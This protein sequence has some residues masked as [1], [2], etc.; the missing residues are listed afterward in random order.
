M[1]RR[2]ILDFRPTV[3]F[4]L[5]HNLNIGNL[6]FGAVG[7]WVLGYVGRQTHFRSVYHV[8]S[9]SLSSIFHTGWYPLPLVRLLLALLQPY[10]HTWCVSIISEASKLM[11]TALH[12]DILRTTKFVVTASRCDWQKNRQEKADR[13]QRDTKG[14]GSQTRCKSSTNS[15]RAV[16]NVWNCQ[17]IW[18]ERLHKGYGMTWSRRNPRI[19]QE[20]QTFEPQRRSDKGILKREE[21]RSSRGESERKANGTKREPKLK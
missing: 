9:F 7:I 18:F 14:K 17:A 11:N 4:N 2:H 19:W 12:S 15:E 20:P 16:K 13:I 21:S 3:W 1:W 6:G 5:S 10:H 8:H